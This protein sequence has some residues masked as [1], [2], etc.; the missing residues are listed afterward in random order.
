V[1]INAWV[2]AIGVYDYKGP[3][4]AT[5]IVGTLFNS[6]KEAED[7]IDTLPEPTNKNGYI[8]LPI[9]DPQ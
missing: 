8:I 4:C 9:G 2:V 1:S 6:Y 5:S 3:F 7:Y